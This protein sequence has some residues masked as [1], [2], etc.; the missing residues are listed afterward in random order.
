MASWQMIDG[1]RSR[2]PITC[3]RPP[4]P[5]T[6]LCTMHYAS[7][8]YLHTPTIQPTTILCTMHYASTIY[9]HKSTIANHY[10]ASTIY[11]RTTLTANHYAS[12]VYYVALKPTNINHTHSVPTKHHQIHCTKMLNTCNQANRAHQSVLS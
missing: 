9:L 11:L 6:I 2:N 10:N 7:T 1:V 3:I 5:T 8:I 12:T 4:S